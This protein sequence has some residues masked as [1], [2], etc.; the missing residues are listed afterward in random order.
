MVNPIKSPHN[1]REKSLPSSITAGR[2]CRSAFPAAFLEGD[3][4][5]DPDG[6]AAS[7]FTEDLSEPFCIPDVGFRI[8]PE[9]TVEQV[10]GIR[11]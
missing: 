6:S 7:V 11:A 1:Y 2:L 4:D 8:V 5:P 10:V 9:G 3:P